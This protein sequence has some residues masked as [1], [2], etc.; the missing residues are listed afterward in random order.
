MSACTSVP[1]DHPQRRYDPGTTGRHRVVRCSLK[2]HPP[3]SDTGRQPLARPAWRR[4]AWR[5]RATRHWRT[6]RRRARIRHHAARP[7]RARHRACH[8]ARAHHR[9]G[10]SLPSAALPP[11]LAAAA[12]TAIAACGGRHLCLPP[13][14]ATA[15][16]ALGGDPLPACDCDCP[17]CVAPPPPFSCPPFCMVYLWRPPSMPTTTGGDCF[18]RS[19]RRPPPCRRLRLPAVCGPSPRRL[20]LPPPFSFPPSCT[21]YVCA[22]CPG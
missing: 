8:H 22:L 18:F 3:Q 16:S 4:P 17:R 14:A 9:G 15:S 12:V 21:I 20:P 7:H 13:P 6:R 5:P 10:G 2:A 1:S 19:R 11:P